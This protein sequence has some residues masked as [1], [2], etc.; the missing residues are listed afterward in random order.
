VKLGGEEAMRTFWKRHAACTNC[1]THCLKLGVLRSGKYAGLVAE[2]PEY[3]SGGLLGTNLGMTK[4]DEMIALIEACDAYGLDNISTG[5]VLG[6]ATEAMEKGALK[7]TDLDGL[8]PKWGDGDTYME[9]IHKIAYKDGKAGKLMA[10]GVAKMSKQIGKGSEAYD[11]T[12]KG[13]E[14]A[15]HDPRGDKARAFSYAMGTCG[16]DHHEGASPQALAMN[17]MVDS[18]V[19]C[20]FTNYLLFGASSDKVITDM[21]NP[22]CGWDWKTE[23][24]WKTAKTIMTAERVF[25]VREGISSKDDRLPIRMYKDK[26]PAGPRKD[27]IFTDADQKD[28]ETKTYAFFGWDEKGIPTEASLKA[29][30]LDYLIPDVNAAKKKYNF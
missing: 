27:A 1:P 5:G 15:A 17:V 14:L 21:L 6:F 16:G 3:E 2:G 25:N 22:L 29:Y 20:S 7:P 10:Q 13:K 9:M 19:I 26:L 11:C 24:Y 18:L 23:D 4:F 8:K 28:M 30:G 12:T